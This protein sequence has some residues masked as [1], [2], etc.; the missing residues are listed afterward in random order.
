MQRLFIV[1]EGEEMRGIVLE[2]SSPPE[3][4]LLT[5]KAIREQVQALAK[6]TWLTHEVLGNNNLREGMRKQ[7]FNS[8]ILNL[9]IGA[10]AEIWYGANGRWEIAT[11]NKGGYGVCYIPPLTN[12]PVCG[13]LIPTG[14]K[15]E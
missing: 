12:C 4:D 15:E 9:P 8:D 10:I 7:V 6:K 1:N 13:A 2:D 5:K 11:E 14:Y 3:G